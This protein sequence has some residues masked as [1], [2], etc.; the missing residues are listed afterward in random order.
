MLLLIKLSNCKD[1][2]ECKKRGPMCSEWCCVLLL[3]GSAQNYS[4]FSSFYQF[5]EVRGPKVGLYFKSL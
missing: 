1:N 4:T 3:F 2:G 5:V